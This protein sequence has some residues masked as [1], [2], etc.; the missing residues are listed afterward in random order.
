M[1]LCFRSSLRPC[2]CA[3]SYQKIRLKW[4]IGV[5]RVFK[6]QFTHNMTFVSHSQ[7]YKRL[8][9]GLHLSTDSVGAETQAALARGTVSVSF[10]DS[11]CPGSRC[12]SRSPPF[13]LTPEQQLGWFSACRVSLTAYNGIRRGIGVSEAGLASLP[14]VRAAQI[15]LSGL[16]A[17]QGT[18]KAS[19]AHL[20]CLNGAVQEKLDALWSSNRF[21]ERPS[22]DED[23]KTVLQTLAYEMPAEAECGS[24]AASSAA[25]VR[26]ITLTLGVYMGGTQSPLKIAAGLANQ[27]RSYKSSKT[28]LVGVCPVRNVK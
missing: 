12:R 11:Q 20:V 10:A 26:S 5:E 7:R 23:L 16:P 27:N 18:I 15:S 8:A 3:V 13:S 14:F 21:T 28:I 9:T 19:R 25:N 22:R 4:D 24:E 17:K 1:S 6:R 2:G